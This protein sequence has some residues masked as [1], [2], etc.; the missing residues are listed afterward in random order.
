LLF[1]W[2]ARIASVITYAC[3][4]EYGW[5][6]ANEGRMTDAAGPYDD[7]GSFVLEHFGDRETSIEDAPIGLLV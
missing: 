4:C 3:M 7:G 2:Q 5:R 1:I 6:A